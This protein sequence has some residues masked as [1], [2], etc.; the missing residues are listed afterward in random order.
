GPRVSTAIDLIYDVAHKSLAK[1]A[2][3]LTQESA[4]TLVAP[5]TD[6]PAMVTRLQSKPYTR[7]PAAPFPSSSLQQEASR[8]LRLGARQSMR[9]AQSLYENGYITYMRTASVT[10]SGEAIRASRAQAAELY[11]SQY[12]P[13]KPRYYRNKSQAAQEAH[14]AIRPA[15]DHF[16]TPAE[17][18][19]QLA[20]DEF[21][22]YELIW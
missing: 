19:G 9:V 22:L 12:V 8:K 10:L 6:A 20:G 21:R 1:S 3:V 4:A 5:L 2:T 7:R 16:R 14:E 11:G 13:D 18:A 15:G 17:V